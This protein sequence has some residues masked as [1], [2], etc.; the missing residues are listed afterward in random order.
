[1]S[2]YENKSVKEKLAANEPVLCARLGYQDPGLVDLVSRLGIDCAWICTEHVAIDPFRLRS[3]IQAVRYGGA[4]ALVRIR[5]SNYSD[6][7]KVLEMGATGLL[8]PWIK[9]ANEVREIVEMSKFYPQGRRGCDGS[10]VDA[11]YGLK[12]FKD[13]LKDAND[14]T[15]IIQIETPEAVENL[16]EIAAVENIDALF[17]GPFHLPRA[18]FVCSN[19]LTTLPKIS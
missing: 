14:S 9:T 16:E 19:I 15:F 6:I 5:P 11:D 4:E 18:L 2:P 17:L 8:I 7:I 13:Y 3:I 1:M 12:P 10:Q